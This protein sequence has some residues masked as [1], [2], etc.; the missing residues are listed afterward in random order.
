MLKKNVRDIFQK[1]VGEKILTIVQKSINK[2]L[3]KK[4]KRVGFYDPNLL[5]ELL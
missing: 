4:S 3:K 5:S 2:K 1:N